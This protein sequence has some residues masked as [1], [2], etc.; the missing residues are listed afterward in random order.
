MKQVLW[1][2]VLAG[3]FVGCGSSSSSSQKSII[4]WFP[5]DNEIT[6]W[7]EDTSVVDNQPKPKIANTKAE[8]EALV[9]GHI[10]IFEQDSQGAARLCWKAMGIEFYKNGDRTLSLEI[11]QLKD[12]SCSQ[13]IYEDSRIKGLAPNWEVLSVED[14]SRILKASKYYQ[15]HLIKKSVFVE[16]EESDS[17][18]DATSKNLTTT[19]ATQLA[20]KLP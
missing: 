5:K 7:V 6:G 1:G 13:A 4:D 10:T 19:F 17:Q 8:A 14:Q 11:Y 18:L 15:L 3:F 12:S 16:I 9:D 2:F 20:A